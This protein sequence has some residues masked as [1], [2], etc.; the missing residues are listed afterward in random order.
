MC[1]NVYP[2]ELA[3]TLERIPFC[4][5]IKWL[6]GGSKFYNPRYIDSELLAVFCCILS[7]LSH[8]HMC[9][10]VYKSTVKLL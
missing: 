6:L 2:N 7:M 1:R 4:F 5:T 8:L 9:L 3:I 10:F